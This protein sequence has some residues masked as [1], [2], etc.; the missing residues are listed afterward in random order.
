MEIIV[1]AE[2]KGYR[3]GEVPI[4]FV[5]RVYGQSKM[6]LDEIV[7]FAFGLVDLAMRY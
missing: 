2:Q 7:R 1:L 4:S 5:D 6:G 3:I